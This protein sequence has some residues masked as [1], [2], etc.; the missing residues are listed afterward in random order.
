[1]K[2]WHRFR[3]PWLEWRHVK[4]TRCP[5]VGDTS[6]RRRTGASTCRSDGGLGRWNRG[7]KISTGDDRL[8]D[9]RSAVSLSAPTVTTCNCSR[10]TFGA[11]GKSFWEI[12][13]VGK[14]RSA[15]PAASRN[16]CSCVLRPSTRG[17]ERPT[18]LI[19]WGGGYYFPD[20]FGMTART[21]G[22]A[23][24]HASAPGLMQKNNTRIIASVSRDRFTR[25]PESLRVFAEA[26]ACWPSW[27]FSMTA[28][29]RQPQGILG[30]GRNSVEVPVSA[31]Y[32]IWGTQ[33][34]PPERRPRWP[35]KSGKRSRAHGRAS[36]RA[37]I[38]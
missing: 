2:C 5:R 22:V 11:V 34:P 28:T 30:E 24:Q 35:A 6:R 19:E 31:R 32:S 29:K 4:S 14:F 12:L 17:F 1:M 16:W 13:S 25:R 20:L 38:G 37:T 7:S 18:T 33:P 15:S 23:L 36:C 9:T 21:A 8:E 3:H 10:A 27:Y 26:T